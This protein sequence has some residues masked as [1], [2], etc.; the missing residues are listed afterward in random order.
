MTHRKANKYCTVLYISGGEITKS[1]AI[2]RNHF[3]HV[4]PQPEGS[5]AS[6]LLG[7]EICFDATQK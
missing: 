5:D 2:E 1:L 6:A 4:L 7:R 3:L